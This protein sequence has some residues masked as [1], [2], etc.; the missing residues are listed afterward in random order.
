MQ[1]KAFNDLRT[2]LT[3]EPVL[4]LYNR[5]AETESHCDAS[6]AGLAG[7][8]LQKGDDRRMHLVYCVLKKTDDVE[9]KYH[10]SK[11]KLLAIMYSLN[12]LRQFLIGIQFTV[13]RVI[14]L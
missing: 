13:Y 1:R 7:M 6:S 9:S 12:R 10:S 4:K 14:T 5:N 8:L 3:T 11:L 2:A